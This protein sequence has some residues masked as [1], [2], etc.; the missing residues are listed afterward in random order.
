[1]RVRPFAALRF[2]AFALSSLLL[3]APLSCAP[4]AHPPA[5][6]A[7][8]RFLAPCSS[9]PNCVSSLAVDAAHHVDPLQ[10]TGDPAH[11][12]DDLRRIIESM[13]RTRI[14]AASNTAL[15]AE[16]RSRVFRFVDDVDLQLDGRVVQIRS[17][18]RTG[19]S[20]WGVNRRRV[21]DIRQAFASRSATSK[22]N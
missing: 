18:S 2:R 13:P 3:L 19:Y 4:H 20:D 10:V 14:V 21:E 12:M 17:A 11:A 9:S 16:F 6:A 15:H 22:N 5:E 1:M 7:P 8:A